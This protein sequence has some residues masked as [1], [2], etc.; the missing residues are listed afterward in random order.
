MG[1]LAS[2]AR[3][4]RP[5]LAPRPSKFRLDISTLQLDFFLLTLPIDSGRN[6]PKAFSRRGSASEKDLARIARRY[7]AY[8]RRQRGSLLAYEEGKARAG[9]CIS[10]LIEASLLRATYGY[11]LDRD[12]AA[13]DQIDGFVTT[14]LINAHT[15]H[16][17]RA[18]W[19]PSF[20]MVPMIGS[21][22]GLNEAPSNSSC[23]LL[24]GCCLVQLLGC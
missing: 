13:L 16:W 17:P 7:G 11:G 22:A 18:R 10:L 8:I 24:Q 2:N 1:T 9:F 23:L 20:V 4:K 5:S 21:P 14:D 19:P 3:E 6:E 12:W 15:A